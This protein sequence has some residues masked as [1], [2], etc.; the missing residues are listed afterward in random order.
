MSNEIKPNHFVLSDLHL[1]HEK[2]LDIC[3]PWFKT[4]QEHD[5]YIIQKI[6]ET[7]GPNDCLWIPGDVAFKREALFRL[8]EVKCRL[9]L[10]GG[11]HDH[12]NADTY[13]RVFDYIKGVGQVRTLAGG[14][15]LTHIPMH[16]DQTRW[17]YNIHGHL[18]TY[19]IDDDR[20]INVCCEALDFTPQR[21]EI[22]I[23]EREIL[24]VRKE[25]QG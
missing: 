19:H 3:R 17:K 24:N 12:F 13:L 4:I 14:I 23:A 7:C 10:I 2:I 22:L 25:T 15:L 1:G 20:Y 21:I 9:G 16:P 8:K 18:H 11:N 6:L 5:D